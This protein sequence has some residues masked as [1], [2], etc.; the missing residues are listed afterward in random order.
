MIV[1]P[2]RP[3]YL[4]EVDIIRLKPLQAIFNRFADTA[5][6]WPGTIP[7]PVLPATASDL[8]REHNLV[9]LSGLSKP[10]ADIGLCFA[11][12]FRAHG[13]SISLGGI[14]EIDTGIEHSVELLMSI[15][16]AILY[17]P[18]HG[19]EANFSYSE[20]GTAQGLHFHEI[21][22]IDCLQPCDMKVE[23]ID[24]PARLRLTSLSRNF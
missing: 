4:I 21:F 13:D 17:A 8:A 6:A 11:V 15:R 1:R 3:M 14:N 2:H 7:N 9:A 20:A 5:A 24:S 18:S 23:S 16:L 22:R 10:G 12:A 19:T